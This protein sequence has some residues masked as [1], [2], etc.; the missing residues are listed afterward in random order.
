MLGITVA[1]KLRRNRK[2]TNHHQR[3]RQHNVYWTSAT[4]ARMVDVLSVKNLDMH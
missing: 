2:I 4:E 1:R 3:N